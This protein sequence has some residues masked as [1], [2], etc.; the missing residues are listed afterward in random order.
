ML[1]RNMHPGPSKKFVFPTKI[2][3]FWFL[4]FTPDQ[5]TVRK[6]SMSNSLDKMHP[7][8]MKGLKYVQTYVETQQK[9]LQQQVN[10]TQYNG[11]FMLWLSFE[12]SSTWNFSF[13]PVV[14]FSYLCVKHTS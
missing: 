5:S 7:R 11:L 13:L 10:V 8:V 6:K 4:K 3:K 12:A 14:G 2:I 9:I 1:Q